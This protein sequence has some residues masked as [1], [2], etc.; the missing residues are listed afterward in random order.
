MATLLPVSNGL[1]TPGALALARQASAPRALAC[2]TGQAPLDALVRWAGRP[3]P[4]PRTR[5]H[6]AAARCSRTPPRGLGSFRRPGPGL[7]HAQPVERPSYKANSI[8]FG[9]H[10]L[11]D[12]ASGRAVSALCA[13]HRTCRAAPLARV[14]AALATY[15]LLLNMMGMLPCASAGCCCCQQARPYRLRQGLCPRPLRVR[16]G[17]MAA[18]TDTAPSQVAVPCLRNPGPPR[19]GWP[20][21]AHLAA[22][23]ASQSTPAWPA[24]LPSA[25]PLRCLSCKYMCVSLGLCHKTVAAC[26][27]RGMVWRNQGNT[28]AESWPSQHRARQKWQRRRPFAPRE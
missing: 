17:L 11:Q 3:R 19:R 8:G 1:S 20:G 23:R 18:E 27:E 16:G 26:P 15:W 4:P 21:A 2:Q 6:A 28:I 22:M 13:E 9:L 24:A 14:C 25:T 12:R 5:H 10:A 7:M